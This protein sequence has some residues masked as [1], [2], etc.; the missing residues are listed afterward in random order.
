M[1]SS[2]LPPSEKVIT[3]F[4]YRI[5]IADL[6]VLFCRAFW[7]FALDGQP[8]CSLGPSVREVAILEFSKG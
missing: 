2:E 5:I 3:H 4:R 8:D 1:A 7:Q 6:D